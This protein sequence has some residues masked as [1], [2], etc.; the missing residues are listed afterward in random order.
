MFI[1]DYEFIIRTEDFTILR[2]NQH[3]VIIDSK[4]IPYNYISTNNIKYEIELGYKFDNK[5]IIKILNEQTN[6]INP[7]LL[8]FLKKRNKNLIGYKFNVITDNKDHSSFCSINMKKF[9]DM[10][11]I[12]EPVETTI[13]VI[14]IFNSEKE[15]D[16]CDEDNDNI[17]YG[18]WLIDENNIDTT[19]MWKT[20]MQ[21]K[22]CSADFFDNKID[23]GSLFLKMKIIE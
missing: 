15:F 9:A 3:I 23:K 1:K 10:Y 11:G 7:E 4:D 21:V 14:E 12:K 22:I 20:P 6:I 17:I 8:D 2:K 5:Q 19:F 16:K 13:E 18:I